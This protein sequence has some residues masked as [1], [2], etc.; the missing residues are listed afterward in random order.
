AEAPKPVETPDSTG[1]VL[2]DPAKIVGGNSGVA[3]DLQWPVPAD[4]AGINPDGKNKV[5]NDEL[6]N[7]VA[8]NKV[9]INVMWTLI[10]G[11]LV[12]FMQ[13][14]FALVETGLCRS[15]TAVHV[16]A[17]NFMIYVLGMVGLWI[18]GFVFMFGDDVN[19]H[20]NIGWQAS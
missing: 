8:H 1:T 2:S 7:N 6:I 12:M 14:G 4:S 9:S 20:V 17:T 10:T 18:C 16:M 13:A 19:G 5:T 15:K 11:F 3:L